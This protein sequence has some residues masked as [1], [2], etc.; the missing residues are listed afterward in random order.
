MLCASSASRIREYPRICGSP[1]CGAQSELTEYCLTQV[2]ISNVPFAICR[3]SVLDK[4]QSSI[5]T[6]SI[7]RQHAASADNNSLLTYLQRRQLVIVRHDISHLDQTRA[8]AFDDSDPGENE[9]KQASGKLVHNA[10]PVD[11]VGRAAQAQH[12]SRGTRLELGK[13]LRGFK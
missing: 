12:G 3:E 2:M 9:R 4:L 13:R 5:K 7:I 11:A 6:C 10:S 1:A 8:L